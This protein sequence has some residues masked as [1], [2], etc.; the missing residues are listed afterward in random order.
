MFTDW[1]TSTMAG[2]ENTLSLKKTTLTIKVKGRSES[3]HNNP[4]RISAKSLK[5]LLMDSLHVIFFEYFK[6]NVL[7]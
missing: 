4:E 2:T 3:T 1:N 6:V 5:I 7:F